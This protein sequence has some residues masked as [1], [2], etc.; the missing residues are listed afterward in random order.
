M[1]IPTIGG[2]A[3][4]KERGAWPAAMDDTQRKLLSFNP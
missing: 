4:Y 3:V 2:A 1:T